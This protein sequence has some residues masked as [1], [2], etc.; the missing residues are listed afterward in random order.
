MSDSLAI[1]CTQVFPRRRIQLPTSCFMYSAQSHTSGSSVANLMHQA[2][3]EVGIVLFVFNKKR[4]KLPN[5]WKQSQDVIFIADLTNLNSFSQGWEVVYKPDIPKINFSIVLSKIDVFRELLTAC[6]SAIDPEN[7]S[8]FRKKFEEDLKNELSDDQIVEKWVASMKQ[9]F[10]NK[11]PQELRENLRFYG[12]VSLVDPLSS[13][14][15]LLQILRQPSMTKHIHSGLFGISDQ[16]LPKKHMGNALQQ[17][18]R[19]HSDPVETWIDEMW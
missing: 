15:I 3:F 12:P 16:F 7:L 14:E 18:D 13:P 19:I 1:E 5:T 8:A 6:R 9:E 11:T 2:R 17:R 4:G 10:V